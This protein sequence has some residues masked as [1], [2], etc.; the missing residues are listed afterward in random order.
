MRDAAILFP[1]AGDIWEG[2]ASTYL[3]KGSNNRWR[4]VLT[5][6]GKPG[7]RPS[8]SP[9]APAGPRWAASPLAIPLNSDRCTTNGRC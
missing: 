9:T 8:W 7:Q 4:D 1:G 3:F 5:K 6:S 2:G